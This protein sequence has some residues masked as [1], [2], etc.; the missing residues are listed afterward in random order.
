MNGDRVEEQVL[1]TASRGVI[2]RVMST[3]SVF[4][5]CFDVSQYRRIRSIYKV[6]N[7]AKYQKY[8]SINF[9]KVSRYYG[10][11]VFTSRQ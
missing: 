2:C 6:S 10:C 3:L 9:S 5:A 8:Q 4:E 7:I 11:F 1:W